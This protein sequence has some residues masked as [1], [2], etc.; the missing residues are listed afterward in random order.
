MDNANNLDMTPDNESKDHF[1]EIPIKDFSY[2]N[3]QDP[4]IKPPKNKAG[5]LLIVL[6]IIAVIAGAALGYLVIK[7]RSNKQKLASSVSNQTK[8][9]LQPLSD[10]GGPTTSYNAINF[11]LS[12]NYPK[13]WTVNSSS[14]S[15]LS[16]TSPTTSL[17][18]DLGKSTLGRAILTVLPKGQLPPLISTSS[19]VA[20]LP[21]QLFTYTKPSQSQAAQ[22]YLSFFQYPSTNVIGGLDA[23]YITGN[24]GYVKTQTVVANDI[25]S[26]DPLVS[27]VFVE[28]QNQSCGSTK[29]LTVS[30]S[31]WNDKSLQE[32]I[33]NMIKS[34]VF[35]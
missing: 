1:K 14:S 34:F 11:S 23:L 6:L 32:P 19:T 21:S 5:K 29:P 7:D 16:F 13:S 31:I 4:N 10:I 22:A 18:S 9:A 26:L 33:L 35:N 8:T 25:K 24:L 2:V 17:K 15:S 20:V 30:S 3:N 27:V 12:V 28:C